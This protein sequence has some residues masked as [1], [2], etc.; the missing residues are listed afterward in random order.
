M[1]V[2]KLIQLLLQVDD[3]D[4]EVYL[5]TDEPRAEWSPQAVD[6]HHK[7]GYRRVVIV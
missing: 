6:L 3:L 7:F 4:L 2:N 1:T 5:S